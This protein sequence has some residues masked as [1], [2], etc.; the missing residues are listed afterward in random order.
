MIVKVRVMFPYDLQQLR[1]LGCDET[2]FLSFGNMHIFKA[3]VNEEQFAALKI[4]PWVE[5]EPMP[6][7]SV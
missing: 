3:V 7:Y 1:D 6:K 2:P 4:L 5:V